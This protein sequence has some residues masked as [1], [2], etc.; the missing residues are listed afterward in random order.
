MYL[1]IKQIRSREIKQKNKK[2]N[3]NFMRWVWLYKDNGDF[4]KRIKQDD[5]LLEH[6]KWSKI[7]VELPK[8]FHLLTDKDVEKITGDTIKHLFDNK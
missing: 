4:V 6:I 7:E 8:I 2:F 5:Q 1:Q 3:E